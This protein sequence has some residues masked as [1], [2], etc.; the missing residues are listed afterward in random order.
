MKKTMKTICVFSITLVLLNLVK[1]DQYNPTA[2]ANDRPASPP[3]GM[4]V[5]L[6]DKVSL[7]MGGGLPL[8]L[9]FVNVAGTH[10]TF[11]NSQMTIIL[12]DEG[13]QQVRDPHKDPF[14]REAAVRN[15]VLE[16]H[17]PE[18]SPKITFNKDFKGLQVGKRYQIVCALPTGGVQVLAGSAW[19]ILSE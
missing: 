18:Y 8:Q 1:A 3:S 17:A 19:F 16:G 12:L 6:P 2:A 9:H 5:S 13:G 4:V 7:N 15:V 11:T 14:Y 10:Y